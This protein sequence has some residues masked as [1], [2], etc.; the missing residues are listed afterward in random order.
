MRSWGCH[1][2]SKIKDRIFINY[3]REDSK[4]ARALYSS[5]MRRRLEPW[6]DRDDIPGGDEWE[7]TIQSAIQESS[8]ILVLLS[9]R[10][11]EK[12]NGYAQKELHMA[13]EE[14]QKSPPGKNFL[15][16]VRLDDCE[17]PEQLKGLNCIDLFQSYKE[18]FGRI[19][20]ALE[21]TPDKGIGAVI[22]R[23]S[24]PLTLTMLGALAATFAVTLVV[25]EK[26]ERAH[27]RDEARAELA[28]ADEDLGPGDRTQ[29]ADSSRPHDKINSALI[30]AQKAADGV[31]DLDD[32]LLLRAVL[33]Q[34]EAKILQQEFATAERLLTDAAKITSNSIRL[35]LD[36]ASLLEARE[37]PK[38]GIKL[39]ENLPRKKLDDSEFSDYVCGVALR[40]ILRRRV[41]EEEPEADLEYLAGIIPRSET[42]N[43]EYGQWLVEH[44]RPGDAIPYLQK[45]SPT[46]YI[47]R[48]ELGEA[49]LQ[50]AYCVSGDNAGGSDAELHFRNAAD[51][52]ADALNNGPA[53]WPKPDY[54]TVS[55][56]YG[57]MLFRLNDFA[58]AGPPV[59]K[60]IK[61]REYGR[62]W[63][64]EA[65]GVETAVLTC[66][67]EE[68]WDELG[69]LLQKAN[70]DFPDNKGFSQARAR[71]GKDG[72][73]KATRE[74]FRKDYCRLQPPPRRNCS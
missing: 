55:V 22:R 52:F 69:R 48:A 28:L 50:V 49:E 14:R 59:W 6:M 41:G 43:A 29:C 4:S 67:G 65:Y 36:Q 51:A 42:I 71:W 44:G 33:V 27:R 23:N 47:A 25:A 57:E 34:A 62:S 9:S 66:Q 37:Q 31:R 7:K 63:M 8:N 39:L 21:V 1:M 72:A 18:G 73:S 64:Q 46:N 16:P 13:L 58:N 24:T 70:S 60:A 2:A 19:L 38:E 61:M 11:L 5:L 32:G 26:K 68:K 40:S 17:I 53:D 30:H 74:A 56:K 35:R 45:T 3:D 20:D 12:K 15:I 10:R 54:A